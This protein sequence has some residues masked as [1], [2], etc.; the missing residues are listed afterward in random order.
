MHPSP[1]ERPSRCTSLPRCASLPRRV[2]LPRCAACTPL[3][4]RV[5]L[6]HRASLS[7]CASLPRR[8]SL[9]GALRACPSP[10]HDLFPPLISSPPRI[11]L[12]V[13]VPPPARV[14]SLPR[15][16]SPPRVPPLAAFDD[17]SL[18][19]YAACCLRVVVTMLRRSCKSESAGIRAGCIRHGV[20]P[21]VG[22]HSNNGDGG[23]GGG[24]DVDAKGRIAEVG[25]C[26][27]RCVMAAKRGCTRPTTPAPA[28]PLN[29]PARGL[30]CG[31]NKSMSLAQL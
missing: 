26:R 24:S 29:K 22:G 20:A 19:A 18:S 31:A 4:Q 25:R 12:P 11:P 14:P 27:C 17:A 6:P 30:S 21:C 28:Q 23:G 10:A 13:H 2:S 7:R 1:G 5:T 15:V 9:P 8:M 16:P 3:P